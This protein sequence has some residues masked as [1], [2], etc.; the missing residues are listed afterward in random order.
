[1]VEILALPSDLGEDV[2]KRSKCLELAFGEM[3][4]RVGLAYDLIATLKQLIG[5]K[6]ATVMSKRKHA[7]G[8]KDNIHAN[9]QITSV[10][11]QIRRLAAQYNDNF[12]RMNTL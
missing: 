10:H 9:S 12:T 5:R 11:L 1:E 2:F 4:I 3:Q 7:R 8:Q 6:S